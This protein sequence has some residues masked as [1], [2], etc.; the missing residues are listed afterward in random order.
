MKTL[1]TVLLLSITIIG[2]ETADKIVAIVDDEIIMKSELDYQVNITA[3][4]TNVK[5]DDPNLRMKVLND[6]ITQK[7]L[8]AQA[9]LDSVVISDEEVEQQLDFQMNY[10]IKQYGSR[11]RVEQTYGMSIDRIKR[12]FRDDTRK[13]MMG[14]RR[15]ME[16]THGK[17]LVTLE[18]P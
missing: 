10:F 7:L 11:E 8:Y 12:E 6:M 17:E 13:Q 1:L 5:P 3:I 14:E 4:Q 16:P 15:G 18:Y 2:Q 9:E